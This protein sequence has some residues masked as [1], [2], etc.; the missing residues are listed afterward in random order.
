MVGRRTF[1]GRSPV[2]ETYDNS[3]GYSNGYARNGD[4]ESGSQ[5]GGARFKDV[6]NLAVSDKKKADITDKLKAGL[7][8]REFEKYYTPQEKVRSEQGNK[9]TSLT[10]GTVGHNQ[11]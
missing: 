3:N 10:G 8:Q 5:S 9:D 4:L 2:H 11:K 6:V 7:E 1:I